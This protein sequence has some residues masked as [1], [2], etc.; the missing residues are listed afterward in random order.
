MQ[1][2]GQ[3][4]PFPFI[5]GFIKNN[6]G[7][8][9]ESYF[10]ILFVAIFSLAAHA[11]VAGAD[12]PSPLPSI[13]TLFHSLLSL[14]SHSLPLF[15]LIVPFLIADI[16]MAKCCPFDGEGHSWHLSDVCAALR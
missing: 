5:K 12:I 6:T 11:A 13:P 9:G 3:E 1:S 10:I 15:P 14:S 7:G 2:I 16:K 8:G 4:G